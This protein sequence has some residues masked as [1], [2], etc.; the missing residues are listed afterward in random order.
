MKTLKWLSVM[1]LALILVAGALIPISA[2]AD[3]PIE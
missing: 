2:A 3:K 1:S